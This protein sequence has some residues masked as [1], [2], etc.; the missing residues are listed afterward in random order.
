MLDHMTGCV[1]ILARKPRAKSFGIDVLRQLYDFCYD[2]SQVG[3]CHDQNSAMKIVQALDA[4][5]PLDQ[6]PA[7]GTRNLLLPPKEFMSSWV[8]LA[9]SEALLL[10][11]FVDKEIF[12]SLLH[13]MC[14]AWPD[15]GHDESDQDDLALLYAV[16][17]LGQRFDV[18]ENTP[19][20][21]RMQG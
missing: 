20:E 11:H 4:P 7:G 15:F 6:S 17:A 16:L 3:R 2:L 1:E 14:S 12:E 13:R 9:F 8:E 5:F 21:R 10:W 18:G 19:K